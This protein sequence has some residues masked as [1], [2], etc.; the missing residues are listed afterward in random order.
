V[1]R[2]ALA[3]LIGA[4]F[5]TGL[6]LSGMTLPSRV[7]GFLDVL[8]RWDPTL[9]L[10]M[11]GAIAVH[12]TSGRFIRRRA[13]PLLDTRFSLPA[14]TLIDARLLVGSAVFGVGW[15]LAGF[16]P[17]PALVSAASGA[18]AALVFCAA[19]LAGMLAHHALPTPPVAR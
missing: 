6:I 3:V 17:G 18:S 14:S 10:V 15:G 8:G 13:K 12:A 1:I 5:G 19:M 16:C 7:L 2:A 4:M 9:A 11:G